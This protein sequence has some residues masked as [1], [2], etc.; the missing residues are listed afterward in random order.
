MHVFHKCD[1]GKERLI[2]NKQLF[3]FLLFIYRFGEQKFH[4]MRTFLC[5]D[6]HAPYL[7][8]LQTTIVWK[9]LLVLLKKTGKQLTVKLG[10]NDLGYNELPFIMNAQ[11]HV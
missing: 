5:I 8:G 2:S 11:I 9:L 7:S 10:Y 1:N 3:L 4:L 6:L